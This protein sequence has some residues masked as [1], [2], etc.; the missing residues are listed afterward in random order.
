L[1]PTKNTIE[2]DDDKTVITLNISG[3][4]KLCGII[5]QPRKPS[6]PPM[7]AVADTRAMSVFVLKGTKMK[8]IRPA[9]TPLVDK[10]P[11]GTVVQS[12][13]I[14]DYEIPGLPTQLEAHI[15][16][17]LTVASPIGINVLCKAGCS[18]IFTDKMC[19]VMYGGKDILRGYKDP[20]LIYGSYPSHLTKCANKENF[21]PPQDPI[22]SP[23]QPNQPSHKP[24]PV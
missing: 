15:V 9:V 19:S 4:H 20:A 12:T 2:E 13:N 21:R 16:P 14:C 11:D 1:Y 22:M 18:V 17:D 24:A 7:H 6:I 3:S 5:M 10:L 8:N 23:M